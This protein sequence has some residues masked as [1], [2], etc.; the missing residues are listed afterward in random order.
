M[1]TTTS[2]VNKDDSQSSPQLTLCNLGPG[3]HDSPGPWEGWGAP[4]LHSQVRRNIK[5]GMNTAWH[6]PKGG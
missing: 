2:C 5:Q 4:N 6:G 3:P 1:K